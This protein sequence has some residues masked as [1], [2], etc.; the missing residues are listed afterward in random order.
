MCS[1]VLSSQAWS[2]HGMRLVV[3]CLHLLV[4]GYVAQLAYAQIGNAGVLACYGIS[5]ASILIIAVGIIVG[6]VF[7]NVLVGIVAS[8][9]IILVEVVRHSAET[10]VVVRISIVGAAVPTIHHRC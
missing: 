2:V 9:Q 1:S 3:T 4:V 7:Q 8:K 5:T 6:Y 10:E